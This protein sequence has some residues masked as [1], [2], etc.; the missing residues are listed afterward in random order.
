MP[1]TEFALIKLRGGHDDLELLEVLMECQEAQDGWMR[2]HQPHACGSRD[3]NLSS[4]YLQQNADPP[5]LLITAPWGSPE[6]HTEW[7]Q[8]HENQSGFA[9]L[10]EYIAPGC[11][12]VLLFHMDSAGEQ[13]QLRCQF[14]TEACLEGCFTVCRISVDSDHKATLQK[15]YQALESETRKLGPEH[16]VW[17]GWRIETSAGAE[18]LVVFSSSTVT[19][20]WVS[21]LASVSGKPDQ[22]LFKHVV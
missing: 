7:L 18:D 1:V 17:A 16:A 14:P 2:R 9:K 12:S 22:R 13:P 11:D 21:E 4:M 20:E 6:A 8:S 19:E 15:E 3:A 5:F 10:S